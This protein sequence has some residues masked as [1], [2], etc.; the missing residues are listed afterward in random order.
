MRSVAASDSGFVAV[1]WD[2]SGGDIDAVV[3]TSSDGVAWS[4]VPHDEAVFGGN[5]T[6]TMRSVAASDRGFVAVGNDS[7]GGDF[8][9]AVWTSPDGVVWSRVPHDEAVFGGDG[10]Q[11][12][13][14][15]V[16]AESG[17]VAVGLEWMGDDNDAAVW[18]SPGGL[19]WSRVPHDEAVFGGESDQD[20][21]SVVGTERGFVAVGEAWLG[22]DPDAAVWTSPDGLA[23]SRVPH[24]AAVFG[25]D[26]SQKI[27]SVTASEF[28][29]VGVGFDRS[30]GDFADAA[31]WTSPDGVVWSRVPHDEEVFGGDANQQMDDV[32]MTESGFVVVGLEETDEDWDAAMWT[33][34]DGVVWSRV[35][36]DEAVFGGDAN[37]QV[38][39]VVSAG[40]GMVAVGD[41]ESGGDFDAAVWVAT[42]E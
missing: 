24:D 32:V 3:W 33:S 38:L 14:D 1:G 12:M 37:Q 6:Q 40:S 18:T 35:P 26:D 31:V 15:V 2:R 22:E 23:W 16:M 4:R 25:G 8:D 9:A 17:F 5:D 7:S 13:D 11:Q 29:F 28:G 34:P 42:R 41:E 20:M 10:D 30:G 27:M 36:H 21:N 19:V 39:S